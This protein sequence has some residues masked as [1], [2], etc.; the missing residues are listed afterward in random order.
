MS[1]IWDLEAPTSFIR[2]P[3]SV[4]ICTLTPFPRGHCLMA[5]GRTEEALAS[6]QQAVVHAPDAKLYQII[7]DVAKREAA[8]RSNPKPRGIG[9]PPDPT[10]WD[11]PPEIAWM[12]WHQQQAVRNPRPLLPGEPPDPTPRPQ[13]PGQP[14]TNPTFGLPQ[15][16]HN[17]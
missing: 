10:L 9:M 13:M 14:F 12:L 17:R 15:S 8:A 2:S 6:H 11:D 4:K 1:V 3:N 5:A 7:Q 16:Q